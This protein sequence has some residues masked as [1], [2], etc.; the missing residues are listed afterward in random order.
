MPDMDVVMLCD[1]LQGGG[2]M[3]PGN[4]MRLSLIS[5]DVSTVFHLWLVLRRLS[6]KPA[7]NNCVTLA[8][9]AFKVIVTPCILSNFGEGG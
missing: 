1:A 2:I 7:M 3:V 5:S 9:E 4:V 6:S 8:P